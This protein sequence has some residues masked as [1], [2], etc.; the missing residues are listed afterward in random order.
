MRTNDTVKHYKIRAA[1]LIKQTG[2]AIGNNQPTMKEVV[3]W[4]VN[5]QPSLSRATWRQYRSALIFFFCGV[6]RKY[7]FGSR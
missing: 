5:K 4:L 1:Q 7:R 6:C 3:I 2:Q